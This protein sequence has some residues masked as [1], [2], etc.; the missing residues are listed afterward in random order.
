M[1]MPGY[2]RTPDGQLVAVPTPVT[3]LEPEERG[4]PREDGFSDILDV[5]KEDII[6][7]EGVALP[8]EEDNSDLFDVSE[9]TKVSPGDVI[10]G[11]DADMSDD[12]LE[13]PTVDVSTVTEVSPG[14]VVGGGDADMSDD[15]LAPE[16]GLTEEDEDDLFGISEEDVM[17]SKPKPRT[18][19]IRR[20]SK[21]YPTPPTTL[22]GM[23]T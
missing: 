6:G 22:G 10:G 4:E 16:L 14:D 15:V 17:G 19:Q 2:I 3:P 11:G 12:V 1:T 20:T 5:T 21:Y 18:P 8:E 13:S 7:T 9:E 23:R